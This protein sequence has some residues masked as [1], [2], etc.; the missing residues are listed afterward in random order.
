M[1]ENLTPRQRKAIEILLTSGNIREAAQAA[2][3]SRET[4]YKWM[5]AQAFREALKEG[6]REALERLSRSLM[7][8]GDKA[9]KAL[10]DALD[11]PEAKSAAKVRPADVILGRLLQ[12]KELADLEERISA[13]EAARNDSQSA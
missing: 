10:E 2:K 4:I 6:S 7:S 12:L 8:L 1:M 5:K 11:D 9:V 3:V 13:L